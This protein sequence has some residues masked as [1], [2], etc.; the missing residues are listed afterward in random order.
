MTAFLHVDLEQVAQVVQARRGAA[1]MA[2]LLDRRGLGV[3]LDHHEAPGVAAA[4]LT[5]DVLPDRLAR[6]VAVADH[7][8][9]VALG[10]EDAPPVLGHPAVT[11]CAHPVAAHGDRGAQIDLVLLE[12]RRPH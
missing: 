8:H 10:E 9:G 12:H 5:G 6:I 7:A 4:V 2:L 1:Q 11:E 3:T